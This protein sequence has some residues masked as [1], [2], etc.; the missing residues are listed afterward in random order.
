MRSSRFLRPKQ[1]QRAVNVQY[2]RPNAV[3]VAAQQLRLC[4]DQRSRLITQPHQIR[5]RKLTGNWLPCTQHLW[6]RFP[7]APP[8]SYNG[9]SDGF[10]ELPCKLLVYKGSIPWVSTKHAGVV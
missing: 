10:T 1:K 3:T 2:A 5:G 7:P 6:V 4:F 9:D 8:I